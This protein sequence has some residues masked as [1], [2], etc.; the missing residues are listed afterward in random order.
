MHH[1]I[2]GPI[3]P[4][5]PAPPAREIA[6]RPEIYAGSRPF[7]GL[8]KYPAQR[9]PP[10]TFGLAVFISI[11]LHLLIFFGFSVR[12]EADKP[13]ALEVGPMIQITMPDLKELDE[14][15]PVEDLVSDEAPDDPGVS[16]PMLADAPT[17][18]PM[19]AFVQA[20]ELRPPVLTETN[21]P[22]LTAVPIKI[23]RGGGAEKLGKIFN[24]AD[25]D[26]APEAI[27]QPAPAFPNHLRRETPEATVTV[28]FIV[29][30]KG[31]VVAPY[32]VE[33]SHPGFEL[34]ATAG[35]EKWKFRPGVKG[36]RK[37]N[38]RMQV[39]LR[40]KVVETKP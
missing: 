7:P 38:A 25:L 18:A 29:D 13:A 30:A 9:R 28:G 5:R 20:V 11:N 39:E 24:L 21:A 23:N 1:D 35:V 14:E 8:W 16:V 15:K 19:D 34:A 37:V 36:G 4:V 2:E 40:F 27:A 12:P 17:I 3:R 32:V 31:G 22:R 6:A 33:S 10:Q 26:R